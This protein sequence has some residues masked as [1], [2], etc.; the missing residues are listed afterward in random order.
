MEDATKKASEKLKE[1]ELETDKNG[2]EDKRL[3]LELA[4]IDQQRCDLRHQ[5]W[6]ESEKRFQDS[7][8]SLRVN[9][10]YNGHTYDYAKYEKAYCKLFTDELSEL[11]KRFEAIDRKTAAAKVARAMDRRVPS[12]I[13]EV[14]RR[15]LDKELPSVMSWLFPE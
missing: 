12:R 1:A 15:M 7:L 5:R 13:E 11:K 8:R 6:K 2:T 9:A 3:A 4:R 14:E 10:P